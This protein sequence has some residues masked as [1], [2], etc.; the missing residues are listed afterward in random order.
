MTNAQHPDSG[1]DHRADVQRITAW[2]RTVGLGDTELAIDLADTFH[3]TG[4]ARQLL[5]EAMA[6]DAAVPD[7]AD[8]ALAKVTE[9]RAW[10]FGEAKSHLED[11]QSSWD[12]L[13]ARLV[14]LGS[15]D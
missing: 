6:C 11:L 15:G 1:S 9:M 7:G 4:R 13:E 12:R 5:A 14:G 10:L 3:A 8:L 2:L